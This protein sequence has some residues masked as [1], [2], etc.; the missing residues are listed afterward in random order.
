MG[1]LSKDS[2]LLMELREVKGLS[3]LVG[4]L[5]QDQKVAQS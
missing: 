1:S 5:K 2:V 3:F 4:W